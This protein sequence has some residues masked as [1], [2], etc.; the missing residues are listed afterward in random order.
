MAS[1]DRDVVVRQLNPNGPCDQLNCN[2]LDIHF[3]PKAAPLNAKGDAVV[4]DPSK[5]Q[6][7]DLGRLEAA[8]IVALGHPAIAVSPAR[9]IEAR[10]DRIQIALREQRLRIE[11]GNDTRLTSGTNV[12]Q[13]PI[14][15]YQQAEKDSTTKIGRFRAAGPGSLHF[16]MDAKKPDQVFQAAWQ[17]SVQLGREKGQPVIVMEGRPELAFGAAGSL[18]GDQIRL[19]LRELDGNSAAGFAV[20]GGSGDKQKQSRLAPDRLIAVG[21][22]VITSPQLVG[23]TQ[24]LLANFQIPA[25]PAASGAPPAA[26]PTAIEKKAKAAPKNAERQQSYEVVADQM[27]LEVFLK[28]Q[29]AVPTTLACDG[30]IVVREVTQAGANQQPTEIRGGQLIVDKLDTKT[31][32]ITLR[33]AS[34]AGANAPVNGGGADG[35]Q[36]AQ[37]SGRGVSLFTAQV[38]MD[39]RDN[40]MWSDGPGEATVLMARDLQ[41][42]ATAT[43]T[44]VKIR[45]QNGLR[46]DGQTI[47]FD[48][49]VVVASADSTLKCDRMLARLAAPLQFGQH[50][51]QTATSFSQIDC[52]GRVAIENLSRDLGG[53]TSHDRM[54]LG[55]LTI[56]QQTG[57]IRGQGPG[58]IR[59]TR[60]GNGMV[61]LA[62]PQD[63]KPPAASP[64]ANGPGNKLHFL[65][66]DFHTGLDGNMYTR[67][68][69]IPRSRALRVWT[70]RCLGAGTGTDSA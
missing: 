8:A 61:P 24:Q 67:D 31:P 21:N 70:G 55:H 59:S 37:L 63:A 49:N 56:N 14:I 52:E 18:M 9:K 32:H 1:V 2:Q 29:T 68:V 3:A 64:A 46:F 6:Q 26:A 50:I 51:D 5:R 69:D 34:G 47:T 36:P 20:G 45:W 4:V 30:N 15:D 33:G 48:H 42:N 38:E 44:P 40:H 62:G 43:P 19:Y 27:R 28:G 23:R 54:Q 65:R 17:K 58:V 25:E 13:A 41:G 11:G 60:F 35:N 10:G 22:V 12:L 16:V 39:G 7:R 66:V 53:V 57:E